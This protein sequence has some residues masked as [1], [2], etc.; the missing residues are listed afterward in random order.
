MFSMKVSKELIEKYHRGECS[1][2]ERSLVEEWLFEDHF[3]EELRLPPGEDK[4]AHGEQ[5]WRGISPV[6]RERRTGRLLSP[7]FPL[8][9][10]R[11]GIAAAVLALVAAGLF[12]WAPT[13]SDNSR[14]PIIEANNISEIDKR[15]IDSDLYTLS[16]GPKSNVRIDQD[17]EV[18][19]LCGSL[20]FVPTE[21]VTLRIVGECPRGES[22]Q[23]VMRLKG[24][25]SYIAFSYRDDTETTELIVVE[26]NQLNTLPVLI[27]KQLITLFKI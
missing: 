22:P 17:R 19:Q 8:T 7:L 16:L 27:Q 25:A 6:L 14:N 2:E 26:Q 18:M 21:N 9:G 20:S 10:I 5:I 12:I 11:T 23:T 4:K 1:E 24:G 3:T 15:D 13:G